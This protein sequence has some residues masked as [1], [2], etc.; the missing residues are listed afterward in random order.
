MK[1]S[2]TIYVYNINYNNNSKY[3][4]M[5]IILHITVINIIII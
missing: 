5:S 2:P 1:L 4:Y 3:T